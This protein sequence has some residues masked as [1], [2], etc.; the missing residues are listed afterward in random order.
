MRKGQQTIHYDYLQET[1]KV[2]VTNRPQQ[3]EN[4]NREIA[5]HENNSWKEHDW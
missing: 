1:E 2:K 5:H 4:N 3:Q